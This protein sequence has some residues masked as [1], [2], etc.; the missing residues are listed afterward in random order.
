MNALRRC[1]L[2]RAPFATHHRGFNKAAALVFC[3]NFVQQPGASAFLLTPCV[4]HS[5][6]II[7]S[8]SRN[9]TSTST[10]S[11]V[12]GVKKGNLPSKVCVVCNRPFTWRKKWESCWDDVTTCSKSC[13]RKRRAL[14]QQRNRLEGQEDL[15]TN[16][17]ILEQ[18]DCIAEELAKQRPDTVREDGFHAQVLD[19]LTRFEV[20]TDDSDNKSESSSHSIDDAHDARAARKARKK[21][22]KAARRAKREGRADPSHG[23]K[24]CD[25]CGKSVDLLVR[26]TIDESA[27][28]KMVCGKCWNSVSGDVVDGDANHP[29]YHYGGLW[30][31]RAKR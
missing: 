2:Q 18:E 13:N 11:M 23:Q 31:N 3:W 5:A 16:L 24:K 19:S 6:S 28:W 21:L 26:C 12:R 27:A 29:Y 30:K 9:I 15:V 8:T 7:Q 22:A 1:A 25:V 17:H 20:R 14:Q 10:L 4:H